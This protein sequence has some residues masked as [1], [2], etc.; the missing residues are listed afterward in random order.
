MDYPLR[1]DLKVGARFPDF[2]LPD[3]EGKPQGLSG[4]LRGFPGALVFNRG[5]Y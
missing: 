1:S 3:Q 2:S 4:L 5:H